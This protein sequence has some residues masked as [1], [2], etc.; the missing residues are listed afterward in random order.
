MRS[1]RLFLLRAPRS[2]LRSSNTKG[3]QLRFPEKLLCIE[4]NRKSLSHPL[5]RLRENRRWLGGL[6][7][8][9]L[10]ARRTSYCTR[11]CMTR[12]RLSHCECKAASHPRRLDH[13]T[14][15]CRILS[16]NHTLRDNRICTR[17]KRVSP[18]P[19]N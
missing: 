13:R 1:P 10:D 2:F 12:N 7:I 11:R 9:A 4:E 8:G 14:T 19:L 6:A 5:R 18:P 15:I 17:P 3:E 16:P